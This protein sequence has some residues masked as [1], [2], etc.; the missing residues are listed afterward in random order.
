MSARKP[1]L[2]SVSYFS[3][4][5][6][7]TSTKIGLWHF[8]IFLIIKSSRDLLHRSSIEQKCPKLQNFLGPTNR[9]KLYITLSLILW[10]VVGLVLTFILPI[11]M[12]ALS[13]TWNLSYFS[14][15]ISAFFIIR[16]FYD[17]I[18]QSTYYVECKTKY[19]RLWPHLCMI[20][21]TR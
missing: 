11:A 17:N 10:A 20:I 12:Y 6:K 21:H 19:L 13:I 9:L 18:R 8:L 1:I 7:T 2:F 5:K 4:E 3:R 15:K 16:S 14:N